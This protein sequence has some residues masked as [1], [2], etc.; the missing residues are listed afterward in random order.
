MRNIYWL[1]ALLLAVGPAH[2]QTS[3][4][5]VRSADNLIVGVY[6]IQW[7]GQLPHK[8]DLLAQVIQHFDVC[9][10]VEIKNEKA[11]ADLAKALEVKTGTAWGYCFGVRTHRPKGDYHEAYGAVWRKDRVELG[12][13][14]ISNTWDRSETFRNDPFLVSFKRQNFD[15]TLMLV[16]TRWSNDPEGSREKEVRALGEQISW[17]RTFLREKDLILGGDFNYAGTDAR[18]KA[19][20]SLAGLTQI[21]RDEKSTF[22]ADYSG[23]ASSYDHLYISSTSTTEFVPTRCRVVDATKVVYGNNTVAS[24]KKSKQELSDHLPVWA[25]FRVDQDDDD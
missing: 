24:M 5:P 20:A 4:L 11:L 12:G 23:Y 19:M 18:M 2:P 25:I 14:L 3:E 1:V 13:G 8:L 10:V 21:D 16:H 7:L 22:K 9:G 17:Y 15:F 6:N